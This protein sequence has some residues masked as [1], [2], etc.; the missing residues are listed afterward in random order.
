MHSITKIGVESQILNSIAEKIEVSK[1]KW[2]PE[3]EEP[4]N[5]ENSM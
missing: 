2:N 4:S 1:Q 3:T 5:M